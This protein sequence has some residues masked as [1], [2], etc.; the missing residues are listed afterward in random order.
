LGKIPDGFFFPFGAEGL[1]GFAQEPMGNLSGLSV[2]FTPFPK[3]F[4][5]RAGIVE[6][7][8]FTNDHLSDD[9]L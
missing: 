9:L 5:S 2:G 8:N 4:F 1:Y 6:Q 7:M 3:G